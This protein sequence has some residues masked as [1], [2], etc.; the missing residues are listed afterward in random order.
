MADVP[1]EL[2][3]QI[4]QKLSFPTLLRVRRVSQSFLAA[5]SAAVLPCLQSSPYSRARLV[6]DIG[7]TY[8]PSLIPSSFDTKH[9]TLTLKPSSV[10]TPF[11]VRLS[12]IDR[13]KP[14][15]I[16]PAKLKWRAWQQEASF[17]LPAVDA[18][19]FSVAQL[20]SMSNA[21]FHTNFRPE[22]ARQS[23]L[24]V[25]KTGVQYIGDRDWILECQ[26]DHEQKA[27]LAEGDQTSLDN[28][29]WHGASGPVILVTVLSAKV[30]LPWIVSGL[31][32]NEF[33]L[34][35]PPSQ[36]FPARYKQAADIAEQKGLPFSSC[37]PFVLEY[38]WNECIEPETLIVTLETLLPTPSEDISTLE[39][40]LSHDENQPKELLSNIKTYNT[41]PPSDQSTY[42]SSLPEALRVTFQKTIATHLP[43][44]LHVLLAPTEFAHRRLAVEKYLSSQ[45]LN[46]DLLFKYG[47]T[48]CFLFTSANDIG[49]LYPDAGVIEACER[50]AQTVVQA[51][52]L[53]MNKR[54]KGG[55]VNPGG[56]GNFMAEGSGDGNG[57]NIA[58]L[59]ALAQRGGRVGW[60]GRR[61]EL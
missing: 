15:Q 33:S 32:P 31:V 41:L 44:H 3:S 18:G 45:Q 35:L 54:D 16:I 47:R 13:S 1:L 30:T 48:R 40:T 59:F 20:A 36:I 9:Q 52:R 11:Q 6:L 14:S 7:S 29:P 2:L 19:A 8:L 37:H 57:R 17:P 42:P 50:E 26:V 12:D 60:G 21:M 10:P 49:K 34:S 5:S 56:M 27:D 38:L 43:P 51:E 58:R 23:Y 55:F 22:R 53:V 46:P 24:N 39:S 4:L 61:A 28:D 25:M